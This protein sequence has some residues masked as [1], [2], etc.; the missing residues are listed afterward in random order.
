V[1]TRVLAV[2]LG[3]TTL[4]TQTSQMP[5]NI[6]GVY[7]PGITVTMPIDRHRVLP[8]IPDRSSLSAQHGGVVAGDLETQV[9]VGADGTVLWAWIP[10]VTSGTAPVLDSTLAALRQWKFTPATL[11]GR[12]V[13]S[14]VLV[15]T[16]FEPSKD[17]RTTKVSTKVAP[18]PERAS[19][20]QSKT[21]LPDAL[22]R[23]MKGVEPPVVLVQLD[24]AYTPYAMQAHVQGDVELDVVVDGGGFVDS[25]RVEKSL[26]G[27]YGLDQQAIEAASHWLFEP[28]R[29]DGK[30]VPMHVTLV[31]SFRLR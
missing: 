13:A 31:L 1:H 10:S 5:P 21:P 8:S 15:R 17:G 3:A 7:L 25:I 22:P 20:V 29:Q 30:R 16:T 6:R 19:V 28:A 18:L 27:T 9:L 12:N 23:A 14:L 11:G 26:D 4:A 24:A 2:V